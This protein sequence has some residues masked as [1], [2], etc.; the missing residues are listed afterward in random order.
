MLV[1]Y[2]RLDEAALLA[3]LKDAGVSI[4]R[5]ARPVFVDPGPRG[6]SKA[7]PSLFSD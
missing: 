5:D 4:D 3:S 6:A 1:R 2:L 7:A